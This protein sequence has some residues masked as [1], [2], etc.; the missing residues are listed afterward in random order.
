MLRR[1]FLKTALMTGAMGLMSPVSRLY[2]AV[3]G[4]YTG[5][6]L[7]Q[8]QVVGGWDVS[9]YCDP[10]EN[11]A[12]EQEITTWS[13]DAET[14]QAGNIPFAPWANNADFFNQH[15]ANMLVINGVDAQTNSHSTGV[16]HNWSGRNAE[17]Y[18]SLTAMFANNYAPDQPLTYVNF[19]GFAYTANLVRYSRLSDVD[20]MR[21][22]L[23][24][25][26]TWG[27]DTTLR[28]EADLTRI[29][30]YR[31]AR[32]GRM[33]EQDSL[34]PRQLDNIS[35]YEQALNSRSAL[36]EFINYLPTSEEILPTQEIN[37]ETSSD[38]QR[39]IQLTMAAFDAG[40]ASASDIVSYG[41]DTHTD[42]DSLHEPLFTHINESLDLLWTMAE[43]LNLA[44]RLTVVIGSDFSRTPW[45]NSDQGKDHWPIGSVI[46]MEQNASW[47]NRVV[48]GTDEG[49]NAFQYNPSTLAR[50]DENGTIIYPAHVHKALRNHLGLAG[51]DADQRYP[52][53]TTED[54]SFFS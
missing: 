22:I 36:D 6:L 43:E 18:P 3:E 20:T 12:G 32:L 33:L 46:V 24:P 41:Y 1:N 26:S 42:H 23:I 2:G 54:F 11:Q 31:M 19:G 9:S 38:L 50:D 44:D 25:E 47:T 17:G 28:S 40:V 51:T 7:I 52:F 37:D 4:G 16:L 5:R 15:Y 21:R 34:T 35:A 13:R 49:Q 30:S 29:R 53:T 14:L 39:Q 10:K 27:E 48:G 8:L 45:Y